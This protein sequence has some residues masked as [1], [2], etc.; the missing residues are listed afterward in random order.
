M[1][2]E[3]DNNDAIHVSMCEKDYTRKEWASLETKVIMQ[4]DMDGSPE[5]GCF[6]AFWLLPINDKE[7]K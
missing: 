3:V 1:I 6:P 7:A 2:N 5:A 4:M